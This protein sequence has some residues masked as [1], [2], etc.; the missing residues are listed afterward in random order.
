MEGKKLE[1]KSI[2]ERHTSE[3]GFS[4]SGALG[5]LD[6]KT[7]ALDAKMKQAEDA[8]SFLATWWEENYGNKLILPTQEQVKEI[9]K[10]FR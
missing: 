7:K 3:K 5:E 4:L 10:T 8:L 2:I 9:N 1:E 6:A